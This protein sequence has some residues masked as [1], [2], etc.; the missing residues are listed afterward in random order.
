MK[1]V[2]G[3]LLALIV[4]GGLIGS[5]HSSD[6][7]SSASASASSAP[8]PASTGSARITMLHGPGADNSCEESDGDARIYVSFTLRNSGSKAGTVEPWA[9]FD[10]S[11]GGH[12]E[13]TYLENYGH[14]LTVP[15]HTEVDATFYHTFNPQ[16]HS[17][18]RC[19][20][21]KDLGD[22]SN[23]GFYLPLR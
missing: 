23:S 14:D 4:I 16:Q 10:Y 7:T 19:A 22:D 20:G 3:G 9:T 13:E 21:F 18:I 8:P 12:S 2:L 6:S 17:L 11:D 15:A 5:H 1:K